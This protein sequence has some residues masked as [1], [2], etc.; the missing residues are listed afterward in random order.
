MEDLRRY[1]AEFDRRYASRSQ[2]AAT[3][4][5]VTNLAGAV[6][7]QVRIVSITLPLLIVGAQNVTNVVWGRAM[8]SAQYETYVAREAIL[9]SG[10]C[11]ISNQTATGLTVTTTA[12]ALISAGARLLVLAYNNI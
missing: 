11:V 4:V 3:Q 10:N 1:Y 2:L 12:T 8:P 5:N 6:S 9:G 7:Q